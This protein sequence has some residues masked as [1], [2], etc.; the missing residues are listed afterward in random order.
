MQIHELF[1]FTGDL[2]S[3]AYLAV[4]N[5]ADTGKVSSTQLLA[6]VN[7]DLA[8]AERDLNGRIDNII[9]G[10]DAPSA[11]EVTDARRGFRG[12]VYDSLGDSIRDQDSDLNDDMLRNCITL[13]DLYSYVGK[14][15][16]FDCVQAVPFYQGYLNNAVPVDIASVNYQLTTKP[17]YVGTGKTLNIK[18]NPGYR[19]YINMLDANFQKQAG[20]GFFTSDATVTTSYDYIAINITKNPYSTSDVINV[21]DK[22]NIKV[23]LLS[24]YTPGNL[25]E[26]VNESVQFKTRN[27]WEFG[28]VDA[29][30]SVIYGTQGTTLYPK[31]KYTLSGIFESDDASYITLNIY[32]NVSAFYTKQITP[33][34]DK[35]FLQ[36]DTG[37]EVIERVFMVATGGSREFTITEV[38]LETNIWSGYAA[39]DSSTWTALPYITDYIE[40]EIDLVEKLK[41]KTSKWEGKKIVYNGDSIT[42]GIWTAEGGARTGFAKVVNKLLKFK[43][44]DNFAVGGTRLARV[45]GEADCMV[46]RITDMSTDGDIVFVM[47]NTNDYASQVPLGNADS[48]DPTEYNGALNTIF[49]WLRTNYPHQPIII[50]TMLTRKINYV[51][52]TSDPLP[53]TIEQYAQAVRDRVKDYHFILYDAYYW[54]GLD[55]RTSPTDG[56]GVT[57]DNLHPN[58]YGAQLLGQKIAAF[59]EAQ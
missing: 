1:D 6:Q 16:I 32:G 3:Q 48:V 31:G 14:A 24:T 53:I 2:D 28:D 57:N 45:A 46:D 36:I 33:S 51:P 27:L 29:N 43:Y 17:F 22:N 56:T 7:Q 5:G 59:I 35:Q 26:K 37:D 21:S 11:A 39:S 20:A 8:Q 9:A 25:T 42:Q 34:S 52:G 44:V 15:E 19:V 40:P 13:M 30:V 18:V 47:A 38:Q 55:L 23:I 49:T 4:D 50:S 54:S 41:E 58:A 12:L 10:G